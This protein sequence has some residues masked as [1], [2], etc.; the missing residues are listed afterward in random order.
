VKTAVEQ[1]RPQYQRFALRLLAL[2]V[3][4]AAILATVAVRVYRTVGDL[5]DANDWVN[6]THQVKEQ[7]VGTIAALRAA[8]AAQRAYII[9][10][11]PPA[12]P[13]C[14]S[15]C[16]R[17]RSA[18]RSCGSW[19]PTIRR[20]RRTRRSSPPCWTSAEKPSTAF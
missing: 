7:V 17:S 12:W 15:P 10:G 1:R 2:F 18:S 4:L 14:T 8:E 13:R 19:S 6:H 5:V 16:R 11:I 9:G 3:V 20:R